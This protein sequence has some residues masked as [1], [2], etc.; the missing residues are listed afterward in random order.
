[1][2]R[3]TFADAFVI[4]DRVLFAGVGCSRDLI[5]KEGLINLDFADVKSVMKD[6]AG[7]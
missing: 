2:R 6:M 3:T 4:A 1:M 7:R 5:V